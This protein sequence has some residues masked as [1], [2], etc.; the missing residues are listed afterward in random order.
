MSGGT[1]RVTAFAIDLFDVALE[2]CAQIG[3]L[4]P[5]MSLVVVSDLP[6]R[7]AACLMMLPAVSF[8]K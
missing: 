6:P 1:S 3:A 4:D 5:A 8:K 7:A 2:R